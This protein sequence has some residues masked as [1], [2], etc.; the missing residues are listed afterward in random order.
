MRKLG[1]RPLIAG[2]LGLVGVA[3]ESGGDLAIYNIEPRAGAT[4]G[5]QPVRITGANFRHDIGYTVYFGAVRSPQVTIL[6]DTTLLVVTPPHDPGTV[7][8]VVAADD[9]PAFRIVGGFAFRE[10]A[11]GVMERVGD[12]APQGHERF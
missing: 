1:L 4:T 7:D 12:V 9:G 10:Q 3:C 11:G 8:V 2:W 6:D 5:E